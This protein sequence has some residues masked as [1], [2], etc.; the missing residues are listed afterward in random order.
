ML[1]HQGGGVFSNYLEVV[2]STISGNYTVGS[3]SNGGGALFIFEATFTQSTISG[4]YTQGGGSH[5]GGIN[6]FTAGSSYSHNITITNST[7]ADN[8][9]L[10]LTSTG[11]GIWNSGLPF[12]LE[13]SILSGNSAGGGQPDL[14]QLAGTLTADYSLIGTGI[15]P[16][17]GVNNFSSDSPLLGPLSDNGGFTLPDG[18]TILTHALAIGS[19]AIDAGDSGFS[20]PPDNDQRGMGFPRVVNS[21]IDIGAFEADIVPPASLVVDILDDEND[22]NYSVGDLSLREAML[23]ANNETLFPGADTITFDASLDGGTILLTQGEL[24]TITTS[25]TIDATSLSSGLTI[26]SSGNDPTPLVNDNNGS[27]VVSINDG[28]ATNIDVELRG[29]TLTGGDGASQGGAIFSTENLTL[30]NSLITGNSVGQ[31]GGVYA[32]LDYGGQLMVNNTAF[33]YNIAGTKGGGLYVLVNDGTATITGSSFA[34]NASGS[35]GGGAYIKTSSTASTTISGSSFTDNTATMQGGGLYLRNNDGTVSITSSTFSDN[36][37]YDNDGGGAYLSSVGASSITT[38]SSSTFDNN[39]AERTGAGLQIRVDGGASATLDSSTVSN[40]HSVGPAVHGGGLALQILDDQGGG[41]T[42]EVVNSTISGN[43]SVG[44]GGGVYVYAESGLVPAIRHSTIAFNTADSDNVEGHTGGGIFTNGTGTSLLLDHTIVS[45]NAAYL[46]TNDLASNNGSFAFDGNYA[47]VQTVGGTTLN[48]SN[49][50]TGF[51]P[52]L[53]ALANNGGPTETH[54]LQLGS[55][56]INGG[57]PAAEA[58]VGTVPLYDQRENP[59]LR[60]FDSLIDIGAFETPTLANPNLVVSSL[61][62]VI[63]GIPRQENSLCGKLSR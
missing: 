30:V 11:G 36:E 49:N 19:P 14:H 27:R 10:A 31:G 12:F 28:T 26:D 56:A 62:D 15:T 9:A 63:D 37:A 46:T 22:G 60:V 61:L 43:D 18:S 32:R 17:V 23:F 33:T 13:N 57:D 51:D 41:A 29:F 42:L 40:N 53:G 47:L 5:G 4:N 2:D 58:G 25:M 44:N 1:V 54:E 16:D 59:F 35:Y 6:A 24:P 3:G 38:I 45:N 52:L 50:I 48:G 34:N 8:H 20:S 21:R 55:I 7:I 39:T